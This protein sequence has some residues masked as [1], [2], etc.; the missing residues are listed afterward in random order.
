MASS[1]RSVPEDLIRQL[2]EEVRIWRQETG[3]GPAAV[4]D[5]TLAAY[6]AG[7]LDAARRKQVE[8]QLA[9]SPELAEM[10][11]VVQEALAQGD[12]QGESP[13]AAARLRLPLVL[14]P[15]VPTEPPAAL[16]AFWRVPRWAA[17]AALAATFLLGIGVGVISNSIR[18]LFRVSTERLGGDTSAT[19]DSGV[20]DSA[21]GQVRKSLADLK[22]EGTAKD[23]KEHKALKEGKQ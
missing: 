12:W 4:D 17:A 9:G 18:D 10:V 5:A 15:R 8:E 23:L 14:G 21:Q 6:A 22:D 11:A 2:A 3:R 16:R 13:E 7:T 20:T 19:L 1:K